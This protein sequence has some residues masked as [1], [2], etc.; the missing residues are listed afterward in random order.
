MIFNDSE[1]LLKV[2]KWALI[3]TLELGLR[4]IL[5]SQMCVQFVQ[6]LNFR[7]LRMCT[8]GT[9]LELAVKS[10]SLP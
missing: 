10:F 7:A 1:T 8:F 3:Y 4:L 2:N 5:L 6:L 9:N